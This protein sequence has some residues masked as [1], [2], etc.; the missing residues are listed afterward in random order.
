MRRITINALVDIGCLVTFIPSLFSG[1]VLY[2][3]LPEGGFRSGWAAYLGI[4]RTQWVAMH[5]NT[6]LAVAALLILHLL[7]HWRFFRH[8]NRHLSPKETGEPGPAE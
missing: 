4:P 7:L 5:N 8:I 3:V 1:L 6:S 2:L